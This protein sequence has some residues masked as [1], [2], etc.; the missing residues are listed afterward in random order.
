MHRLTEA[1]GQFGQNQCAR[2][3]R[4][5]RRQRGPVQALWHA[6][7]LETS[8]PGAADAFL[9]EGLKG[10]QFITRTPDGGWRVQNPAPPDST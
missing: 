3:A 2:R 9:L 1:S 6:R 7:V 4:A 10:F 5:V 8:R